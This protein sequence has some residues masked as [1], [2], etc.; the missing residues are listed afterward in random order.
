MIHLKGKTTLVDILKGLALG[1]TIILVLSSPSGA[2]RLIEEVKH[3]LKWRNRKNLR[4]QEMLKKLYYLR[5]KKLIA[6][7]EHKGVTEIVLTEAGRRAVLRYDIET[8]KLTIPRQWDGHWRL[9][10]FDI[11]EFLKAARG[12]LTHKLKELGFLQ[13]NKSVWVYP[14]ECHKE[15]EFVSEFF[16]VG[17]YVHYATTA[18]IT[19]DYLLRQKF[20]L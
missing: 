14:Y 5:H 20:N 8:L 12:A 4:R 16:L 2:R 9:V 18:S 11:P 15:I 7:K 13:L 6:F 17:K 10:F 19:N 1:A 3:E